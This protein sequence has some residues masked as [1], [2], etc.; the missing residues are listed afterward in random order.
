MYLSSILL[1]HGAP[2]N[3]IDVRGF[4]PLFWAVRSSSMK[5]IIEL[6]DHGAD[7]N[8]IA[9]DDFLPVEG[10]VFQKTPL[11][12]AR[13][14]DIIRLLLLLGADPGQKAK[15]HIRKKINAPLIKG[16]FL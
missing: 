11:F 5:N 2:P 14:Y 8:H 16:T 10:H 9:V 3:C 13:T 6:I 7:V 1:H 12:R 4:T 15:M